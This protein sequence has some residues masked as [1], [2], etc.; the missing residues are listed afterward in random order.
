M[1][2]CVNTRFFRI[3]YVGANNF[4]PCP[5]TQN[6]LIETMLRIRIQL[7]GLLCSGLVLLSA[8]DQAEMPSSALS[9][10][11]ELEA[12]PPTGTIVPGRYIVVL[13]DQSEFAGKTVRRVMTDMIATDGVQANHQYETALLGFS[14]E[15]SDAAIERIR[16]SPYVDYV[17]PDRVITL[18]PITIEGG[19][20]NG[21]KPKDG[22]SG[23][24][25]PAQNT[26]WGIT[27]VGGV[28]DGSGMTA[29][30]IDSGI[31][32][33]H[34]D[35]NVDFGRSISLLNGKQSDNPDDQHGHGTHVA[36]TIAAINNDIGVVGV[37]AGATVV[38]VRVLDR[39]GSG[40]TSGVIDGVDYV[41]ANGAAG[42]V[43]NMS[44]G[45]G[46][47]QALN[48]AVIAASELVNFSLAA[49]NESTDASTRSPASANGGNIYTISAFS[50]GDDWAS[51]S[52]W[53]AP[54]DWSAP[55]VG[56][57][58][59]WKNGGYNTIS[60][61]SMAAPHVAGILL[62]GLKDSNETVNGDP[63][64]VPDPIAHW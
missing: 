26:P 40:Y 16:Q 28:G 52:N 34:P 27:R 11:V 45:G 54:V 20:G 57:Q 42:D 7:F 23:G 47:S 25:E 2:D 36:G 31:D 44:L 46:F 58:S 64:N 21:R 35:L 51:F 39:R 19:Q 53:G 49:G 38:S 22:G 13:K 9:E 37:A 4:W 32:L 41:A 6:H 10:D 30:V 29:W 12:P 43:A 1:L 60:G 63:D 33:D 5:I 3:H 48:D 56:I 24:S 8:C 59:L 17:E 50:Q 14:G 18:P 55:G 61:T 15:F 62:L